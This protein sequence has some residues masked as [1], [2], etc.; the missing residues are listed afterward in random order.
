MSLEA[1][2]NGSHWHDGTGSSRWRGK[3]GSCQA[4]QHGRPGKRKTPRDTPWTVIRLAHHRSRDIPGGTLMAV[5]GTLLS[6]HSF[7]LGVRVLSAGPVG[8]RAARVS[9]RT[10]LG[11]C[12]CLRE[13]RLSRRSY[14]NSYGSPTMGWRGN[15]H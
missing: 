7:R 12:V 13:E 3:F 14:W 5:Y 10:G 6:R 1:Q 4:Q 15:S 9:V 11:A 8:N 2:E